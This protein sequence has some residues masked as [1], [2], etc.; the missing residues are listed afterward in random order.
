MKCSQGCNNGHSSSL[1]RGFA[2]PWYLVFLLFLAYLLSFLDRQIIALLIDPIK[3]DLHITDFQ[4]S[5]LHGL[6]FGVFFALFGIPI[7][8]AADRW[9]RTRIIGLGIVVW[10]LMTA[11]CG[12]ARSYFQ[13]FLGRIGVGVGEAAL[14][15]AAYSLLADVFDR[16]RL[17]TAMAV[18]SMGSTL[19]S[20][21]AFLLGGRLLS[22]LAEWDRSHISWLAGFADWQLAFV[23]AG[24][25]GLLLAL[26][27]FRYPEPARK[28]LLDTS[29]QTVNRQLRTT[30]HFMLGHKRLYF[31][32]FI[33]IAATTAMSSGFIVWTPV[34]L[35]RE[36]GLSPPEAARHF[37]SIFVLAATAGVMAGGIAASRLQPR[38]GQSAYLVVM[39]VAMS[40]TLLSIIPMPLLSEL[41]AVS[42]LIAAAVFFTQ[43]LAA[44][45]VASIQVVTPN[46][47]R[48]QLSSYFLL[49]VNLLGY[50]SGAP[51]IA[52]VTDFV[53]GDAAQLGL[54]LSLAAMVLLPIAL[55]AVCI[56]WPH[57]K[58]ADN[59]A[60]AEEG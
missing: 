17:P 10:S 22:A 29:A 13:L 49:F 7:A 15:P 18:F 32:I 55:I 52:A 3:N 27:V 1:S 26:F 48:A 8:L 4:F 42:L 30:F 37:G 20:G 47:K 44:V 50:G 56:A 5:L 19:G 16:K 39:L 57:Y 40:G 14:A 59:Y 31:G 53:L 6:G 9:R 28:G 60:M 24:L 38:F 51:L 41:Q 36:F 54:S 33:A 2:S 12:M 45:S 43:S 34:Y 11:Y 35:M 21:L 58:I 25:P 23:F 46:E